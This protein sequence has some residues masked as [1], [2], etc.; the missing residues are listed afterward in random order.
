MSAM[1]LSPPPPP[2]PTSSSS[3]YFPSLNVST[4]MGSLY[5]AML[6]PGKVDFAETKTSNGGANASSFA[7][8][9]SY[10]APSPSSYDD[11]SSLD[12]KTTTIM[13][14]RSPGMTTEPRL[15]VAT[16]RYIQSL[17]ASVAGEPS[18]VIF[19]V[20]DG[21]HGVG[22]DPFVSTRLLYASRDTYF[23]IEPWVLE[24]FSG[25]LLGPTITRSPLRWTQPLPCPLSFHEAAN[26]AHYDS[27]VPIKTAVDIVRHMETV[28][29]SID[30]RL[31]RVLDG[32]MAQKVADLTPFFQKSTGTNNPLPPAGARPRNNKG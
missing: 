22:M 9:P 26:G 21:G 28:R 27:D 20:F 17:A 13:I 25:A 24:M 3:S 7:P 5:V 10:Y 4:A 1:Q 8:A 11:I 2:S 14:K 30:E 15:G 12:A 32:V 31:D 23:G 18:Q 19:G 16:E 6:P 29:A